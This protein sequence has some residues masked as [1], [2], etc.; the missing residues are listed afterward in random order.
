MGYNHN[1]NHWLEDLMTDLDKL[2]EINL[3][4]LVTSFGWEQFPFL[5]MILRNL[6]KHTAHRFAQMMLDFDANVATKGLDEASKVLL[7][8]FA[9]TVTVYGK[10]NIPSGSVLALSNHPGMVDT[11][12]LFSALGRQDLKIIA[13]QRPFLE[14]LT[15]LSRALHFITDE[16]G[17]SIS[18]V[19]RTRK[20]LGEGGAVLTFPAGKIDPDPGV[21][22][23]AREALQQWT[24]SAGVFL[25]LCPETVLL[26]IVVR[27]VIW[28]KTANSLIVKILHHDQKKREKLAAALQL[29]SHVSLGLHPLDVVVQVGEPISFLDVERRNTEEVHHR[30]L[31]AIR[32]LISQNQWEGGIRIL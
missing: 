10:E 16:P 30:L 23:G 27:G 8:K 5:S 19:K 29:I 14:A 18:L 15:N 6:F 32:S 7:K 2:T 3:D 25:R 1:T 22:R 17:E 24:D 20:H 9:R 31:E 11:L 21:Y 4:D 13:I 28:T 12:A 26:P